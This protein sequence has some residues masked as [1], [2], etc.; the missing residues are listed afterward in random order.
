MEIR[1][2]ERNI[3][4]NLKN[5]NR[6]L[7]D[8]NI[9]ETIDL[10]GLYEKDSEDCYDYRF[11]L[12]VTPFFT[13]VLYNYKTI[14]SIDNRV[15][16]G[17][18]VFNK[19]PLRS[20]IPFYKGEK[21]TNKKEFYTFEECVDRS[22]IE[23]DGWFGFYDPLEF[24]DLPISGDTVVEHNTFK[25]LFPT[26]KDLCMSKEGNWE[27]SIG[28]CKEKYEDHF[29]VKDGIPVVVNEEVLY[30]NKPFKIIKTAY[31]HNLKEGDE[32]VFNTRDYEG[33]YKIKVYK[34]GDLH[35]KDSHDTFMIGPIINDAIP[36][37][38][39]FGDVLNYY[40][41]KKVKNKLCKYYVRKYEK[42]KDI[43]VG[44][45][46]TENSFACNL[47]GDKKMLIQIVDKIN[48]NPNNIRDH[49]N[50]PITDFFLKLTKTGGSDVDNGF[51]GIANGFHTHFLYSEADMGDMGKYSSIYWN[52]VDTEGSDNWEDNSEA[53]DIVEYNPITTEETSVCN[54]MEKFNT[55]QRKDGGVDFELETEIGPLSFILGSMNECYMYKPY[56]RINIKQKSDTKNTIKF[57]GLYYYDK[58]ESDIIELEEGYEQL[59]Y[60]ENNSKAY[61]NTGIVPT[62]ETGVKNEFMS[63]GVFE[64]EGSR[65]WGMMVASR[66]YVDGNGQDDRFYSPY[67]SGDGKFNAGWNTDL[68]IGKEIDLYRWYK[69]SINYQNNRIITIDDEN[70]HEIKE[71]L[72]E[73]SSPLHIFA[74]NQD[75]SSPYTGT[76]AKLKY[77]IITS[78][79]E[80]KQ[81]LIPCINPKGVVG[82]YDIKNSKFYAPTNGELKAGPRVNKGKYDGY[83]K[84]VMS[85]SNEFTILTGKEKFSDGMIFYKINN[86]NKIREYVDFKTTYH[87]VKTQGGF[88]FKINDYNIGEIYDIKD[89]D[90]FICISTIVPPHITREEKNVFK[91]FNFD[92]DSNKNSIIYN[93]NTKNVY[94]DINFYLEREDPFDYLNKQ[95]TFKNKFLELTTQ[96]GEKIISK[97]NKPITNYDKC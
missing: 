7:I 53:I 23:K 26:N 15:Y 66:T 73:N 42:L 93:N 85:S 65:V 25:H 92:V 83:E 6:Y 46:L 17:F 35:D 56:H 13:N 50:K 40:I 89:N 63:T 11:N 12:N 61:I 41:H 58:T 64:S 37:I 30:H 38:D 77:N 52:I 10:Y 39:I 82:M 3:V 28:Y 49:L 69:T 4:L 21:I 88:N 80:I 57:N 78:G 44:K 70:V 96:S 94:T 16:Y 19:V 36:D 34:I 20:K 72:S 62:D 33:I 45:N 76:M 32:I 1:N 24:K 74:I 51:T 71:T 59:E 86:F 75:T 95:F 60:V 27:I 91:W 22:F 87:L 14:D 2:K 90:V 29:L 68:S 43:V 55:K 84:I 9:Q 79:N 31:N 8:N 18:D 81:H 67:S 97:P 5:D 47:Y 54:I 48:I